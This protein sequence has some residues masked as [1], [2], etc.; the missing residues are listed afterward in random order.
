MGWLPQTCLVFFLAKYDRSWIL[1]YLVQI[2]PNFIPFAGFVSLLKDVATF[3]IIRIRFPTYPCRIQFPLMECYR[4]SKTYC[5]FFCKVQATHPDLGLFADLLGHERSC[6]HLVIWLLE[7]SSQILASRSSVAPF[8]GW[9]VDDKVTRI[10][11]KNLILGTR[12]RN[13]I[14]VETRRHIPKKKETKKRTNKQTNKQTW[15]R[16]GSSCQP[17]NRR[18]LTASIS[19]KKCT[20]SEREAGGDGGILP[21]HS[22]AFHTFL[23]YICIS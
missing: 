9:S 3:F 23:L 21:S 10:S 7:V 5:Q 6:F 15:R 1:I 18:L 13:W 8:E 17:C 11:M 12:K 16:Y 4:S 22:F 2:T 20:R 19:R 14:E